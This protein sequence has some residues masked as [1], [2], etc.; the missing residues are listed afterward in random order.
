MNGEDHEPENPA[1]LGKQP[2]LLEAQEEDCGTE[3]T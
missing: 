3:F 2:E 1:Q